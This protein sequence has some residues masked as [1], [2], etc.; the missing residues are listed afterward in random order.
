MNYG[1]FLH[2]DRAH[3]TTFEALDDLGLLRRHNTSIATLNFVQ[4][5]KMC[6]YQ[7]RGKKGEERQQQHARSARGAQSRCRADIVSESKVRRGH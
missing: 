2:E 1:T 6:P 5:R 4:Y 7:K 3:D